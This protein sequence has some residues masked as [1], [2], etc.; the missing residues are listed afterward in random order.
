[1]A[2]PR[3]RDFLPCRRAHERRAF[4]AN[5]Y[6]VAQQ[7]CKLGSY[8]QSSNG[9]RSEAQKPGPS[10][11]RQQLN[12]DAVIAERPPGDDR[13]PEINYDCTRQS[14]PRTRA[15]HGTSKVASY[16][17]SH[18]ERLIKG[19]G[20]G[21]YACQ[22]SKH[23]VRAPKGHRMPAELSCTESDVCCGVLSNRIA[24]DRDPQ[25]LSTDGQ[26]T[27]GQRI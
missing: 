25:H 8:S 19:L 12:E 2:S 6:L 11:D 14:F 27:S 17:V 22:Q 4:A 9:G 16:G 7:S 15:A 21:G 5:Q 26:H 1:M 23:A 3:V 24:I 13:A 18:Q 10:C 20:R